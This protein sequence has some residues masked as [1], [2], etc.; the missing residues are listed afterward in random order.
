M[1]RAPIV[2]AGTVAGMA[3][4]LSFKPH[5][6]SPPT[7]VAATPAT[8][9]ASG[10]SSSKSSSSAKATKDGTFTGDAIA[11][12]Y[13]SAQVKVTV[14]N[15][16]ITTIEALALPSDEPKS[17]QIST[18]AEPTLKEQALTKQSAA[19]DGVSGATITSA[20]YEASLQSALD[21]AGFKADDGSRGSSTI[22]DV[23]EHDGDRGGFGGDGVPPGFTPP[24]G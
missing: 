23:E 14:E 10:A 12:R 18:Q 6:A 17:V 7:A 11:T 19:I 22:P 5:E 8:S 15:G 2:I 21:A 13:G 16:K 9:G 3:A 24:Q 20:G 1:R 4:V